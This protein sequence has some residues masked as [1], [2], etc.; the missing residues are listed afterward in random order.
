MFTYIST[1]WVLPSFIGPPV[2][3]WLTSAFSWHWVFIA[4]LPLVA[5]GGAMVLPT[6]LIMIRAY[7]PQEGEPAARPAALWAAG[8]VAVA[9]AAINWLDNDWTGSGWRCLLPALRGCW[10]ACPG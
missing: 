8:L 3:A 9:A 1:A 2:A 6:L 5:L 7:R 4:V 10:S